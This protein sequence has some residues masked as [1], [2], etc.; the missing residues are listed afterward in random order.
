MSRQTILIIDDDPDTQKIMRRALEADGFDV[1]I[2]ADGEAGLALARE[3]K[4]AAITLDI[5]MPGLDG[6][7]VL[8][9]LKDDPELSEIPV[10]LLTMVDEAQTGYAL[11]AAEYI[12]KPFEH[13]RLATLLR[14]IGQPASWKT[15]LVLEDDIDMRKLVTGTLTREGWTVHEAAHGGEAVDLLL[16]GLKPELILC[17]LMMPEMD[18]FEF[19]EMLRGNPAWHKIPV[20]VVTSKEL[21]ASDMERLNGAATEIVQKNNYDIGD[22]VDKVRSQISAVAELR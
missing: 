20:V 1:I 13:E 10:V 17:D 18:G 12:V 15:V 22:L 9:K 8:K 7:D 2:A 21:T 4:P 14:K 11:G 3:R 19:L 16:A 5:L 6:W